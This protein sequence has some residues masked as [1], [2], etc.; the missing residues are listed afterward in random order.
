[1]KKDIKRHPR[2]IK[3]LKVRYSYFSKRSQ[4]LN[5]C[6]GNKFPY[7]KNKC[8]D[9]KMCKTFFNSKLCNYIKKA[10]SLEERK[11]N[12]YAVMN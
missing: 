3:A 9:F 1:M 2:K 5:D 8:D 12:E 7:C 11:D 10:L 6:F 4:D